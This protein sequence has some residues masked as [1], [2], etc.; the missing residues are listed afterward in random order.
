MVSAD[1]VNWAIDRV[2]QFHRRRA[3]PVMDASRRRLVGDFSAADTGRLA[4]L[5]NRRVGAMVEVRGN[6]IPHVL[7]RERNMTTESMHIGTTCVDERDSLP[8]S[9]TTP[10]PLRGRHWGTA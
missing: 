4:S 10:S 1:E 2:R 7:F 5:P 8:S 9:L 6:Q 3:G